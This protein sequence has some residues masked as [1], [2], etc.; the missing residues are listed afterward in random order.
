MT[1]NQNHSW[2]ISIN[3][4]KELQKRLARRIKVCNLPMYIHKIA[5]FDV[6]YLNNRDMLIAGMVILEYPSLKI[7]E[8]FVITDRITFPYI[9]GYLSFR[10]APPLIKL[11]DEYSKEI[12]I[13]IFDGHG[14][15]HP[16]GFG[17][18]SH[19]GVL[20]NKPSIGCAKKKL[21]GEYEM[22]APEKGSH[23]DLV[24]KGQ[25]V[26]K[27]LRTRKEKKPVFISIGNRVNL[28]QA[29]ELILKCSEKYRIPE[30]TR[31][32]HHLVSVHKDTIN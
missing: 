8:R 9:P 23:S 20:I 3:E 7:L 17:I 2:Q 31:R 19:I 12:D 5:G 21:V 26:G 13:F 18:A 24:Y 14:I 22:P 15:A 32:A 25:I 1:K 16:R 27:V 30:P 29:T 4:A 11:I 6:S 10:E 28:N